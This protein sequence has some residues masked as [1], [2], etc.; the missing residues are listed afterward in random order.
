MRR[1]RPGCRAA[2]R[3]YELSPSH[4]DCHGILPVGVARNGEDLT[5]L[6]LDFMKNLLRALSL[7][8]PALPDREGIHE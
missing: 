1:E 6:Q 5:T 7:F 4:V 8:S 2:Q 3:G